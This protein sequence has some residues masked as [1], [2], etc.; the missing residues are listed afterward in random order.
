MM[1]GVSKTA[2]WVNTPE[3]SEAHPVLVKEDIGHR[4]FFAKRAERNRL[5]VIFQ[6]DISN[7]FQMP[8]KVTTEF[9]GY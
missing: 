8:I 9:R 3:N 1:H 2:T 4:S 5:E 7:I 6:L